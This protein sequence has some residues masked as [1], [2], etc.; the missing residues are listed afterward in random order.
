M[1]T[2]ICRP[3]GQALLFRLHVLCLSLSGSSSPSSSS[4]CSLCPFRYLLFTLY[5]SLARS[6]TSAFL[7]LA[8]P[9]GFWHHSFLYFLRL[10][11]SSPSPYV[12]TCGKVEKKS[13]RLSSSLSFL[14]HPTSG[15]VDASLHCTVKSFP[16]SHA[17]TCSHKL[18]QGPRSE[19]VEM[20]YDPA[21]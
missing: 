6:F 2:A 18:M 11:P 14:H 15:D 17:V 8:H 9:P 12:S 16:P 1:A 13:R 10:P 19:I 3:W 7:F 21:L 20:I 4:L 5:R